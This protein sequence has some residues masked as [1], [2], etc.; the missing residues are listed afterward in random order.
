MD[1]EVVLYV[2]VYQLFFLHIKHF[3]QKVYSN[4]L[5]LQT[6]GVFDKLVKCLH[7]LATYGAALLCPEHQRTPDWRRIYRVERD[8]KENVECFEVHAVQLLL[9]T[10]VCD[11]CTH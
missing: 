8:F 10:V 6:Y 2:S 3:T 9:R 1:A 4:C 11:S 5:L 7:L